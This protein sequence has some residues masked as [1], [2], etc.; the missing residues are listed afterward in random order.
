MATLEQ[1]HAQLVK[2]QRQIEEEMFDAPPKDWAEFQGR[3]YAHRE[4]SKLINDMN[5]A[6]KGR[7]DDQ[8]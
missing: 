3:Q 8:P 6:I 1:F 2:R 4:V 7:E 5:D